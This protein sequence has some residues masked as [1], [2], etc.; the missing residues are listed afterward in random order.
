MEVSD[1]MKGDK[2]QLFEIVDGEIK[3]P[4]DFI[5][6]KLGFYFDAEEIR[7]GNLLKCLKKNPDKCEYSIPV[8]STNYCICSL[9]I[10]MARSEEI[11]L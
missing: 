5:C 11:K 6:F 10:H 3:C 4:K 8:G 7:D 9:R 1:N 2:H